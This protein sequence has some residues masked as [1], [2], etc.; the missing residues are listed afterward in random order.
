MLTSIV[1][2]LISVP[3][4]KGKGALIRQALRFVDGRAVRSR[5]GPIMRV[6]SG[7]QTNF[8]CL[9]GRNASEYGDVYDEMREYLKPGMAFLDIGANAGLFSLVASKL[10]TDSGTVVSFEPSLHVFQDLVMNAALNNANNLLPFNLAISKNT[11]KAMFKSG[12]SHHSGIGMLSDQGDI[13]VVQVNLADMLPL[14]DAVLRDRMIFMKIDVEGAEVWA[15]DGLRSVFS[16]YNVVRVVI[17]ISP[18]QLARF[19][20][21]SHQIYET[22][23]ASGFRA[24]LRGGGRAHFNEVFVRDTGGID[25]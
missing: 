3:E 14:L 9:S 6:R 15:L 16:N 21:T 1:N 19:G 7:D 5:Y 13:S 20:S 10:V 4:F 24:A 18:E 23:S 22:L 8:F 11:S 2:G 17:E 12:S 25:A